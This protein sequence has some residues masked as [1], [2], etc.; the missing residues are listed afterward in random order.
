[1]PFTLWSDSVIMD[2]VARGA[3]PFG[4]L[5]VE[6]RSFC[7]AREWVFRSVLAEVIAEKGRIRPFSWVLAVKPPNVSV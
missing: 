6:E 2:G 4:E 7:G 5:R 1:M 3:V